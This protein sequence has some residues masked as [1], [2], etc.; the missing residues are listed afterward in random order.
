MQYYVS[1]GNKDKTITSTKFYSSLE[2]ALVVGKS[3]MAH[4]CEPNDQ[5]IQIGNRTKVFTSAYQRNAQNEW[6]ALYNPVWS[7]E[8]LQKQKQRYLYI[9]VPR[10]KDMA[11]RTGWGWANA[12]VELFQT[13]LGIEFLDLKEKWQDHVE[14]ST[15]HKTYYRL[16]YSC[17]I[18]EQS[19]D[20]LRR[21]YGCEVS[22]R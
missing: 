22:E 16:K 6:I 7:N 4:C 5:Y 9:K 20:S 2:T 13:K 18:P 14:R 21:A 1:V 17:I 15:N 12:V 8:M 19:L 11:F 10:T 3:M